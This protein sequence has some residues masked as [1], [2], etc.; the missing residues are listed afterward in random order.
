M[1]NDP[2][3]KTEQDPAQDP[4]QNPDQ[5]DA[6]GAQLAQDGSEE[7]GEVAVETEVEVEIEAA[8]EPAAAP[9]TATSALSK[10]IA[11]VQQAR[12]S[13]RDRLLRM[14]AE[15]DNFKKRSKRDTRD[16]VKRAEERVVLEFLPVVD[17]LERALAHS[18]PECGEAAVAG[19]ADGVRMVHKQFLTT[20]EKYDI[21]PFESVGQAFA[22]ERHEAVQ[23]M[24]SVEPAF[25]VCKELQKGYLRGD[26]LVR[27]AL[28]IVS[29]GPA[30]AAGEVEQG[31]APQQDDTAPASPTAEDES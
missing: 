9:V 24:P 11:A 25:A 15:H 1:P 5:E 23:Q 21:R 31:E 6:D 14:A 4:A 10:A 16:S 28:V 27:P 3:E 8:V 2:N 22:P 29:T 13:D 12:A 26:H 17:N 7:R 18:D 20:L 19:L 30:A